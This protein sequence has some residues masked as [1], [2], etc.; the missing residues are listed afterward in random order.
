MER[1]LAAGREAAGNEGAVGVDLRLP[2]EHERAVADRVDVDVAAVE[3]QRG[4]AVIVQIGDVANVV[5][6]TDRT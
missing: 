5:I 4:V 3:V 1:G 6:S 2:G